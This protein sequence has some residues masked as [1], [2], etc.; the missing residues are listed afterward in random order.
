MV[1]ADAAGVA[2]T[3]DP[4]TG[5]RDRVVIDAVPGVA[6][7]LVSGAAAPQRWIVADGAHPRL[8]EEQGPDA[9]DAAGAAA[10]AALA[11][12]VERLQGAPQDVEWAISSGL[13]VLLQA[14][15]ITALGSPEIGPQ[16]EPVAVDV[17]VPPGYWTREGSHSPTPWTALSHEIHAHRTPALTRVSAE[18]G[19]LFETLDFRDIG[20]WEYTRVV[21]LGGKQPPRLP[22]WATALAVRLVPALRER[23]RTAARAAQERRAQGLIEDWERVELGRLN[24]TILGLRDTDLT[25]LDDPA[26]GEHLRRAMRLMEDGT[27]VHFRLH[28]ALALVLGELAFVVRDL[29]G[30]DDVQALALLAGTSRRS[31]EPAR[32]LAALATLAR[33]RPGLAAAIESGA[34]PTDVLAL[35]ADFRRDRA[36]RCPDRRRPGRGAGL[37]RPLDGNCPRDPWRGRVLPDQAGGRHGLHHHLTGVV[38]GLPQHRRTCHRHR[39]HPVPPGDHRA[40][41][42]APRSRRH[43]GG[44]DPAARRAGRAGRRHRRHREAD[45]RGAV[46]T[47]TDAPVAEGSATL[48]ELTHIP[49]RP[50]SR[51]RPAPGHPFI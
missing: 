39:R 21:P 33:E 19:Y 24:E 16:V 36:G 14:R 13:P 3:A 40:R 8:V 12:R 43:P 35:D 51:R 28:G 34:P 6:E 38:G 26:L 2:F 47:T 18:L 7:Q 45:R 37:R 10:V 41:V 44:H 29:L 9:L 20:G 11:R 49:R 5:A 30:W 27:N 22:G 32:A 31:T 25:G 23:V 17:Q 1:D 50:P 42:R 15:P 48:V 4:V 46:V